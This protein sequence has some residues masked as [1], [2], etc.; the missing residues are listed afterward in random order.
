MTA[1]VDEGV[2]DGAAGC[3]LSMRAKG[4]NGCSEWDEGEACGWYCCLSECSGFSGEYEY[5]RGDQ[6][7]TVMVVEGE[8]TAGRGM[9][10]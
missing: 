5:G 8:C 10:P 6:P 2:A 1:V 4:R 3:T 9:R 7:W